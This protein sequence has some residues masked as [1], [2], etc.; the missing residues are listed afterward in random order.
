MPEELRIINPDSQL[1]FLLS[2]VLQPEDD[3]GRQR[4][5]RGVIGSVDQVRAIGAGLARRGERGRGVLQRLRK[6]ELRA[7]LQQDNHILSETW[8][9]ILL[10]E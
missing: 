4:A 10:P 7:F 5:R 2:N 3:A 1:A 6:V 8:S 9:N